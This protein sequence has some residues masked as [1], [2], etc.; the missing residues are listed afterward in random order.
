MTNSKQERLLVFAHLLV[1]FF[2]GAI[3]LANAFQTN[4]WYDEAYS[5]A[6]AWHPFN[7]IWTIG[8]KDVHPV[9]YYFGLHLVYLVFGSNIIAYRIFTVLGTVALSALGFTHLRR[10]TDPKTA[11]VFSAFAYFMA[12][13]IRI[14]FQVRMYSWLAF[15]F[16]I[17]AIYAWRILSTVKKGPDSGNEIPT[18]WWVLLFVF[19]AVSAYLHY[20]G[21]MAAF[22]VQV[23][24]IAA[25]VKYRAGKR[26]IL[27]WL[28][29]AVVA[30]LCYLPW[31]KAILAQ[32]TMMANGS[33]WIKFEGTETVGRILTF[34]FSAPEIEHIPDN[35]FLAPAGVVVLTLT[36]AAFCVAAIYSYGRARGLALSKGG[37]PE[38]G[39]MILKNPAS[40]GFAVF[41]ITVILAL[42]VSLAIGQAFLYYRYLVVAVGP[43]AL[44]MAYV[45]T[46]THDWRIGWAT[47]ALVI[48]CGAAAYGFLFE[49]S[50]NEESYD[51]IELYGELCSYA[52]ELNGGE[53]PVVIGTD[54]YT[55]SI[56]AAS[57]IGS[58]ITYISD[59]DIPAYEA[60]EPRFIRGKKIDEV[61]GDY[62]GTAVFLI[63]EDEAKRLGEQYGGHIVRYEY[64]FHNYSSRW[65]NYCVMSFD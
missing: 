36:T 2:G 59:A 16:M 56:L 37:K 15:A 46:R 3:M 48:A 63:N 10:D 44:A 29:C 12:M 20:Y 61:L 41:A 30:V 58:P 21:A 27:I 28:G 34:P 50:H 38:S 9:L 24:V 1:I 51:S 32:A 43:L 62:H 6:I 49:M 42:A 14:T 33:Y 19:S 57:G 18:H 17:V 55:N 54:V 53:E 65:F 45:F 11:I 26:S 39:G 25:L 40:F 5:V 35:V 13:S 7:E 4:I 23:I 22:G 52:E 8:A 64:A 47:I 60:F 31:L